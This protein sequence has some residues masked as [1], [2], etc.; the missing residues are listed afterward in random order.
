MHHPEVIGRQHIA[1][2]FFAKRTVEIA[3]CLESLAFVAQ[4]SPTHIVAAFCFAVSPHSTASEAAKHADRDRKRSGDFL[5]LRIGDAQRG[6]TR[7]ASYAGSNEPT[8]FANGHLY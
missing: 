3:I 1:A 2:P 7:G 8:A 5:T 4:Q 6:V